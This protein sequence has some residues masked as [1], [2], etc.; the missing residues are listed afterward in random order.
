MRDLGMAVVVIAVLI[1]NVPAMM[2]QWRTDRPGS[3][4]TLWIAGAYVIYVVLGVWFVFAVMAPEGAHGP[5]VLYAIGLL[6]G[7]IFYG[8]LTLVR[9]V[10]RYRALPHWLLHFGVTDVVLLALIFGCA[11][12]YLWT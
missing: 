1:A 7:W 12:A 2:Q 8:L 5:K 10:P 4:K 9:V 11:A 3:I 6:F